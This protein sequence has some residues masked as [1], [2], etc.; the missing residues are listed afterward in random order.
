[1]HVC[2][3]VAEQKT[4]K[5]QK[6]KETYTPNTNSRNLTKPESISTPPY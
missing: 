1:M 5:D 3:S 2:T 4:Q 6:W